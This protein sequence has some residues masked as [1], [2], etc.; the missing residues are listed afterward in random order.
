[1]AT[2]SITSIG[3]SGLRAANL[4]LLTA[5]HNVANASTP[6]YTRQETI[7]SSNLPLY[8]GAGYLGQGTSVD[9]VKRVY[10]QHLARQ[11]LTAQT[12]SSELDQYSQQIAE[13]DNLLA[14]TSAGLSPAVQEFFSAAAEVSAN[15][16]SI[17]AR[18]TMLAS[19]QAL[20]SR[21]Q[22]LDARMTEMQQGVNS[23]VSSST[24]LISSYARQIADINE[25]IHVAQG[26]GEGQT[27]NDLLDQREQLI[28]EL[29]KEVRVNTAVQSDGSYN[30]YIGNG[31]PLVVGAQ[32]YSLEAVPSA[33][34][35]NRLSVGL[36][37]AGGTVVELPESAVSGGKLA[38][39][40]G[41][42]SETLDQAQ[43]ALGRIAAGMAQ[44]INAQH[45]LGQD[46]NGVAGGDFFIPP[47]GEAIARN[48]PA[49]AGDAAF[50]VGITDAAALTTSDYRLT[51][52][53]G[54][55]YTLVRLSDNTTLVNNAALPASVDGFSLTLSSGSD[56]AGDSFLI[57]PTRNAA[58]N[59]EV[60]ITDPR[61]IAA[62]APIRTGQTAGNTGT[63][64]ISAGTVNAPPPA[65]PNL[66]NSVEIRFTSATTFDV[67]DTTLGTNLATGV[68]YT[69][70]ADIS[71][72]GWT[73]QV[74]GVAR[75]GDQFTV[76]ANTSGVS[77]NRNLLAIGKLQTDKTMAG[78]TANYQSAY[79]QMVSTVG[80]KAQEVQVAAAAQTNLVS[81]TEAAR[82]S[83]S[84][85][86]LD[87]EM[88]KLLRYQQAYQAAAKTIE[89]ANKLFDTVLGMGA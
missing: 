82:D 63:A 45:Q 37:T 11:V 21:F 16:S 58:Q 73:A 80:N 66:K 86:N 26:Y 72:N 12:R 39:A 67:V 87:E 14:D 55:S 79:S 47:A 71:Y 15:P 88:A 17:P 74:S 27:P 24:E 56:Q 4:G 3:L 32:A 68:G 49:N 1:M 89:V 25:R 33:D 5:G 40:L 61:E 23:V 70:G 78:G 35:P 10:D 42:R 69:S 6:G 41:F 20:A 34:D 54:G 28:A 13:L 59:L 9:T 19:S 60:A 62:A 53:G 36:T 83:V 64:S 48:S 30:V 44:T 29:N 57:R 22:A 52:N 38:G 18:Q 84:G 31:Q 43:S 50:S 81:Q 77:D 2:N 85:V 75:T 51:S 8:T 76:G 7:Q 65:D 46:L